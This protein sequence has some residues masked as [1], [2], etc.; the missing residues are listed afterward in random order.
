MFNVMLP[1]SK[2]LQN[3]YVHIDTSKCNLKFFEESLIDKRN[4]TDSVSVSVFRAAE[5]MMEE[6]GADI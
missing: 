3:Y 4:N 5:V 2:Y 6:W 1:C